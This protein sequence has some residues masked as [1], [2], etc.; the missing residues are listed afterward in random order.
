MPTIP[1]RGTPKPWIV[2]RKPT[3][4]GNEGPDADFYNSRTWR[5]LRKYVLSGEPLCR[6]CGVPAQV[7]D[8]IRPISQG[9]AKLDIENLQPLC[10]R[11]HNKKSSKEGREKMRESHDEENE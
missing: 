7:V 11:C 3:F 4:K 9:G 5:T 8:H 6:S 1:K 10:S 2:K